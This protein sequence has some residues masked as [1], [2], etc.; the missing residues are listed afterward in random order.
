MTNNTSSTALDSFQ[1]AYSPKH[2]DATVSEIRQGSLPNKLDA[3]LLTRAGVSE[4]G[5]TGVLRSFK[6]FGFVD[7]DGVFTERGKSLRG[8]GSGSQKAALEALGECY[9]H[10]WPRCQRSDFDSS[11]LGDYISSHMTQGESA[12]DSARRTLLW[13]IYQSGNED[14]A[15]R[16]GYSEGAVSNRT[17]ATKKVK[18]TQPSKQGGA[19]GRKSNDQGSNATIQHNASEVD[20]LV[21][22]V[23]VDRFGAL[24]Q[25]LD[26]KIDA[27]SSPELVREIRDLL[28]VLLDVGHAGGQDADS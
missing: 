9:P 22:Q 5:R 23:R 15:E 20:S 27:S 1:Y 12:R 28:V 13:L 17:K 7:N 19:P 4:S 2:L 10:L 18:Q 3:S 6:A 26:V 21:P 11:A 24:A 14:I 25:I 8:T 16:L